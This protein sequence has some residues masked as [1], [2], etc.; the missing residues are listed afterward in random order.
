MSDPN[1]NDDVWS[2][3][4][5]MPYNHCSSLYHVSVTVPSVAVK[6]PADHANLDM[7]IQTDIPT[8]MINYIGCTVDIRP[9]E[10]I[11]RVE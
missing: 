10:L 9:N 1:I 4:F 11:L 2:C 8:G 5:A 3:I 7:H 6:K